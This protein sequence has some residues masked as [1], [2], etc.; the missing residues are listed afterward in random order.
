MAAVG[1]LAKYSTK[2]SN[3]VVMPLVGL[4]TWQVLSL[5]LKFVFNAYIFRPKIGLN[6][7]L[8]YKLLWMPAIG[9]LIPLMLMEMRRIWGISLPTFSKREPSNAKTFSSRPNFH[10]NVTN[11]K[12]PKRL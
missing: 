11:P 12:M 3:G 7:I 6:S 8:L 9:I 1:S 2:L 5:F 4:G 10:S